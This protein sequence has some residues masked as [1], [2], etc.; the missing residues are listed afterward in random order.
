MKFGLSDRVIE[1][2]RAVF[3][4]YEN[5]EKILI[6]GSRAKGNFREG[7][8]IDLC[9]VGQ[10]VTAA[11]LLA[12]LTDIDDLEL[13]YS[14]DLIDYHKVKDTPIGDHISRIGQI[15][16]QAGRTDLRQS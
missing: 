8:D 2:F 14:V 10:G 11:Q 12:M 13:L 1:E 4:R 5:I 7:S 3:R 6:F 16:Y 15:F 9:A